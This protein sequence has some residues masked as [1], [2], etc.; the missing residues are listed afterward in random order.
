MAWEL[1][2]THPFKDIGKIRSE[3]D[4]LLDT[5]LFGIPQMKS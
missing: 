4:R 3:M 2:N 5:F 1:M